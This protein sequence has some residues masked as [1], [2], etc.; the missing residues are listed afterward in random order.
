MKHQFI[1]DTNETVKIPNNVLSAIKSD[2]ILITVEGWTGKKT[3]Q[4]LGYYF[5]GV[6]KEAADYFGWEVWEMHEYLK[7]ECN[8]KQLVDK[9]GEIHE[10]SGS[11]AVLNK[12]DYSL[13]VDRSIRHLADKGFSAKT[14]EEHFEQVTTC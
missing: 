4:Q 3:K 6:V 1:A 11:T 7:S 8:K 10:V 5:A 9:L 2:R 13:F 12:Y 14:P